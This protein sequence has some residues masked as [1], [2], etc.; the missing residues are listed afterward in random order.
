MDDKSTIRLQGA[1]MNT[2]KGL[3]LLLLGCIITLTSIAGAFAEDGAESKATTISFIRP[4]DVMTIGQK[5]KLSV[6]G[7]EIAKLGHNKVAV[8][9]TDKGKHKFET[10]VGLSLAVPVTGFG[11]AKKF[12]SKVNLDKG[13]HFFKIEFKAAMMG[14][15]HLIIEIDEAEYNELFSK[16]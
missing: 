2:F 8:Y 16:I 7:K 9:E 6:D 4:T 14:G 11:G 13:Q 10:K 5:V 12:K 1:T 3:K 15:K